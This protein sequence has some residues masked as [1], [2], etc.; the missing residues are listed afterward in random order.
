MSRFPERCPAKKRTRASPV[1]ATTSF[2][3][4]E[5]LIKVQREHLEE[6]MTLITPDL[7]HPDPKGEAFNFKRRM[8]LNR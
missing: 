3:P 7:G 8:S 1:R 4:I 6:L 2:R 5:D